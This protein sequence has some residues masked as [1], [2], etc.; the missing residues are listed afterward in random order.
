MFKSK[1][2]A[3]GPDFK[4]VLT[5]PVIPSNKVS[6]TS[7]S[8]PAATLAA[9]SPAEPPTPSIMAAVATPFA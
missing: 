2:A 5:C 6:A 1:P 4:T 3:T 7:C 9:A 8:C